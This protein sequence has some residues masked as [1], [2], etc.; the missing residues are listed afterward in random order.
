MPSSELD[1]VIAC[2][3]P[4]DETLGSSRVPLRL[5]AEL[6]KMGVAVS[7]IFADDLPSV[8]PGRLDHLTAPF[9]M[10]S[11][12]ATKARRAHVVDIAGFD[13]WAYARF[14]RHRRAGQAVVSRSNGLWYRALDADGESQSGQVR[15]L[16]S[17]VF[18][19]HVFCRWERTSITYSHFA[20]FGSRPDRDDVVGVGWKSASETAVIHP[21]V[22][23]FFLS[24]VPLE[25]R[26]GVAFAG[27][28]FRRKGSDVLAAAMSRVMRDRPN[29]TLTLFG[30]GVPAPLVISEFEP[31][32]RNRVKVVEALPATELARQLGR[33]AVFLFPT[34]Y[35][36]FGIV[37]L[38]AMRAG[39]AVVTTP[40]GAG[41]DIVVHD[42]NGL[43]VPI[44]AVDETAAA[45]ARLVDDSPLRIRL[46]RAAIKDA[47]DRSWAKAASALTDAYAQARR[48]AGSRRR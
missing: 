27:T 39:L 18:Q 35:E 31:A 15:R 34:R 32:I 24:P 45:V 29:L 3:F 14:A 28:F 36:G 44:G 48:L 46:A 23:E 11:V 41:N 25:A 6:S 9:R 30:A 40:T 13:A 17:R 22:D 26:D 5:I 10:A 2:N 42:E 8:P 47:E 1:V 7:A 33:H 43:L 19:K 38:E 21:G 12:L 4:R 37:V 16:A 20:L